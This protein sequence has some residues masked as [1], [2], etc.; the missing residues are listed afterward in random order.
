MSTLACKFKPLLLHMLGSDLR[1]EFKTNKQT[2]KTTAF[3]ISSKVVK[4]PL[5]ILIMMNLQT[6]V[7]SHDFQELYCHSG[8]HFGNVVNA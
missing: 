8:F 3:P 1:V 7:Q 4:I 6:C 2:K 5:I